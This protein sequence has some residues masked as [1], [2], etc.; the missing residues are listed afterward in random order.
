MNQQPVSY[1]F[2][3]IKKFETPLKKIESMSK[4]GKIQRTQCKTLLLQVI[5]I[6]SEPYNSYQ[7]EPNKQNFLVRDIANLSH[8]S[9]I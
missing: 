3:Q 8:L 9:T 2:F 4:S 1:N 5:G 7:T 6:L